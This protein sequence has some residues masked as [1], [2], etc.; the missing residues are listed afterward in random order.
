[1]TKPQRPSSASV[2][3]VVLRRRF[4]A[5]RELVF[6]AWTSPDH[7]KHWL[8]P[9]PEWS[10]PVVE[11]DLRVGGQYRLGFQHPDEPEVVFVVGRFLEVEE[12]VRLVYTWTWVPPDPHA[13]L[14]T[15][16]TVQFETVDGETEVTVM[17]ERFPDDDIRQRHSDGWTGTLDCLNQYL[18]TL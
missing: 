3:P 5:P 2:T 8:H 12:G 6:S 17:H 10:N 7:M 15:R 4:S 1:M 16:V 13:G 9:S 11:V 14:E 18:G